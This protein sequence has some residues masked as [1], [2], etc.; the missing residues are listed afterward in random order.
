MTAPYERISIEQ[1][2]RYPRPGMGGPMR[3]SFT[4]DGSGITYLASEDGGL[5]RSLWLYD[6]A[7]GER[8]ALAGPAGGAGRSRGRRS[9]AGSARACA[10]S[11]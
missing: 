7:T 1:V 6:I 11:A 10:T 4:P 2:A 8:R 3:W 5:V 9:C